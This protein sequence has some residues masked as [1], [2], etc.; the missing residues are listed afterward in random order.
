MSKLFPQDC[1]T[2]GK[3]CRY[4]SSYDLNIDDMV[5][6]CGKLKKKVDDCDAY[7]PF[8]MPLLCPLSDEEFEEACK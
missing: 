3:G 6:C 8:Y 1:N 5:S 7:G 4:F 2:T